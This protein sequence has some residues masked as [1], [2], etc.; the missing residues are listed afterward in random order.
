MV[1]KT[2]LTIGSSTIVVQRQYTC[3]TGRIR[4]IQVGVDL[5]YAASAGTR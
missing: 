4:T 5:A 3:T 1:D 2:D